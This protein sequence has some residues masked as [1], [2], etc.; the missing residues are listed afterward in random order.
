MMTGSLNTCTISG[1]V[2]LTQQ[3]HADLQRKG[4][5]NRAISFS[6][7]SET[8][9]CVATAVQSSAATATDT[10]ESQKVKQEKHPQSQASFKRSQ[11][12]EAVLPANK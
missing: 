2:R 4:M 8:F 7:I 11:Q 1:R 9:A 5:P 12:V 3:H 10:D 6:A